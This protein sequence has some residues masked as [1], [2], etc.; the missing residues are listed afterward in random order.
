LFGALVKAATAGHYH[1]YYNV[2]H[3]FVHGSSNTDGSFHGRT[4]NYGGWPYTNYCAVGDTRNGLYA[5]EYTYGT[6]LCNIWSG[7]YGGSKDECLGASAN[8]VGGSVLAY[9]NHYSHYYTGQPCNN[10]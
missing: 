2:R 3:G 1:E 6:T 7:V 9:H 5:D 10:S 8:E 4:D